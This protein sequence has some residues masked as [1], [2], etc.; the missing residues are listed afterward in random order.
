MRIVLIGGKGGVASLLVQAW[1]DEHELVLVDRR[2]EP[3]PGTEH[4]V[5]EADDP[6]V[7][8][9]AMHGADAVVHLAA[10]LPIGT[11]EEH[12][13]MTAQA[14]AV[15]VG[16]V[17]LALRIARCEGIASFV[18]ISSLSVFTRYGREV[19][20]ADAVPD[21]TDLYGLS[22]RV[23]EQA[24]R[25]AVEEPAPTAQE[26]PIR[27]TSLRLAFPATAEMWPKWQP[28]HR[29]DWTPVLHRT[30]EGLAVGSLHEEDLATAVLTAISRTAGG[31]YETVAVSGA[32]HAYDDG[33]ASRLLGWVPRH[34][35]DPQ[36]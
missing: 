36:A 9:R 13:P 16:T 24:L 33:S 17:L 25:I 27:V 12:L 29:P 23:A 30:R 31:P 32:P 26:Q 21:A 1:K 5:G 19:L 11:E 2:P 7:L 4:V 14:F 8:R 6:E 15:N 35:C 34:V 18:H 3:V 10:V 20:P 28:F 22:K